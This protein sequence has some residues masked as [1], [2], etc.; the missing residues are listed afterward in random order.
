MLYSVIV[1]LAVKSVGKFT[2]KDIEKFKVDYVTRISS[3]GLE[4]GQ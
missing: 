3:K 2:D 4:F 1:H